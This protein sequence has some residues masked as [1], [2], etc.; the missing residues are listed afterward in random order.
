[1]CRYNN[2]RQVSIL[3]AISKVFERLMFYQINE[4]MND[5][6][7]IFLCGFRKGMSAQNCLLFMVEKWRRHLDKYDKA[8]ILLTDLSKAFDCL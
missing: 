7:S 3:P 1:M 4:Y 5:K 6:L 2:Y 8:G